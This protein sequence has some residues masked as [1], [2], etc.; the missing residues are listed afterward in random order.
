MA[1]PQ[2]VVLRQRICRGAGGGCGALF[3]ICPPCDRGQRYCSPA[4]RTQARIQ[5][6]RRANRRYQLSPEGRADHRDRQ[7]AYRCRRRQPRA[8]VT[9]P[10]SPSIVS[11]SSC[12]SRLRETD[13]RT[14]ATALAQRR[15]PAPIL[16]S[17]PR[18]RMCGRSGRFVNPYPRWPKPG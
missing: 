7:A 8:C 4:C 1:V 2:E 13:L 17:Q 10:S 6:T 16:H 14:A 5:Q 9:D 11:P 3:F 12:S 15:T 18:C